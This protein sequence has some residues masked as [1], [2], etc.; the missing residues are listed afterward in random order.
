MVQ[1]RRLTLGECYQLEALLARKIGIRE[2]ARQLERS[3]STIS[4]EIDRSTKDPCPYRAERSY[5]VRVQ[6]K[7]QSKYCLQV[8]Q[9]PLEH[10]VR[11]KIA[12]DW[13]PEQIAGRLA[14]DRKCKVVSYQTIYRFI[15]RDKVRGGTLW[16]HLR[17]RRKTCSGMANLHYRLKKLYPGRTMIDERPQEVEKRKRLGDYERDTVLGTHNGTLL[18]TI[19]DR[20]SRLLKLGWLPKKSSELT[21]ALTVKLLQGEPVQTITNDNGSEFARYQQTARA[22]ETHVYFSRAYRSWERGTNENTNGLLRQ[23]FPRKKDIGMPSPKK[24]KA[25]ER[26]INERPRKCL[27]FQTPFEVHQRLKGQGVALDV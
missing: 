17:I 19:V 10:D 24:I 11:S 27:G 14:M 8:I 20:T 23:Y 26:L 25:V 9:G 3:P 16:K 15:R 4:R 21:H 13:S 18:L 6:R 22:L 1:Y 2:I 12:L 7:H 5:Q